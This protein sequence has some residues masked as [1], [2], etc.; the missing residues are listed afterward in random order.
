MVQIFFCRS[1]LDE[2]KRRELDRLKKL[3]RRQNDKKNGI[4]RKHIKIPHHLDASIDRFDVDD[5]KKL[6]VATS[7]D[8]NER[9]RERRE[10]FKRY[11]MEKKFEKDMRLEAISDTQERKVVQEEMERMEFKHRQHE[12]VKMPMTKAQLEEVWENQDHMDKRDFNPKTFFMMHDLDGNEHLDENELRILFQG[13]LQKVYDP[14]APEDDMREKEE[15]MERMRE[16]VMKEADINRDRF[17]S[18]KEF[19]VETQREEYYRNA[20]WQTLD[21]V[22][23]D[24]ELF[25]DEEYQKFRQRRKQEVQELQRSGRMPENFPFPNIPAMPPVGYGRN[26]PTPPAQPP[27]P[28]QQQQQQPQ[29][30]QQQ[31]PPPPPQQEQGQDQ[32][33]EAR[34]TTTTTTASGT[35]S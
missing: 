31:P 21:Q 22:D 9:D 15:E 28:R 19:L 18:Y 29:Q 32:Q 1:Q 20:Y 14:A 23:Q 24:Q 34:A 33:Q 26:Q 5:L 6:I 2:V 7:D 30:Q 27:T 4:D 16:Y 13:E 3:A 8:L 25:T 17:I 12:K 10:E 11:E 35:A